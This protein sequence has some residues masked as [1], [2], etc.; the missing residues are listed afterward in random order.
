MREEDYA[1]RARLR[2]LE[3]EHREWSHRQMASTIGYSVAWVKK[4]RKRLRG[5]PAGGEEV[6]R[7]LPHRPKRPL[8]RLDERVIERILEIRAEPPDHLCRTPGPKALR[9]FLEQDAG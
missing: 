2:M 8:P 7:D 3:R 4:W 1:A 5:A 6:L 9:Y